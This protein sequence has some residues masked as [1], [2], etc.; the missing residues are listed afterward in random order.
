MTPPPEH[1]LQLVSKYSLCS[2]DTA[3]YYA[4]TFMILERGIIMARTFLYARVSTPDQKTENQFIE[5][6]AAG[7]SI[8]PHRMIEETVSGSTSAS[9]REG[10]NKLL[11]RMESGDRLIV[12]KL[13][14]LG[15]DMIDLVQT[16]K[17]LED[18]GIRV[19]C[20]ALGGTDLTSAAGKM[21]MGV[22]ATVAQFERDQL[23][24]RTNAGLQRAKKEG[25]RLGRPPV[26]SSGNV[27]A[28]KQQGASQSKAA[29]ELEVS[30]STI[31]RLW[32]V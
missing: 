16:V 31:K 28:L 26:T 6:Q 9:Q 11:E 3:M 23:I 18:M 20:L 14:R 24:E 22:L 15:R 25:K 4:P 21:T 8:E 29:A 13:D 27:Q 7:F 19:H 32:N 12:S 1:P 10:F 5:A 2:I 17:R 30:I